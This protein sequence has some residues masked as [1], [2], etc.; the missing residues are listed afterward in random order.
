MLKV[1][2]VVPHLEY[3]SLAAQAM[4]VLLALPGEQVHRRVC[5][6]GRAGPWA[7]RLRH[8]GIEV[9]AA[10]RG[11]LFDLAP[12]A[13]LRRLVNEQTPD[14]VHAWGLS[15]LRALALS[16]FRGR[17]I[18]T[19]LA[20][21]S[22]FRSW[23][24]LLD[25]W[26]LRK[27]N[28]V[29]ALGDIDAERCSRLGVGAARLTVA[30]PAVSPGEGAPTPLP[31][32][33]RYLLC[34]GRLEPYKGFL[35]AI[36][37]HDILRYVHPEL[38]LVIVG[39]GPDRDRLQRFRDDVGSAATVDFVG[40]V[41]D[42]APLLRGAEVVWSPGRA[43]T[44]TQVVLEA[45]A[46]GKPVIASRWPRLAELIVDGE[47]GFLVPAQDQPALARRTEQLLHD[48]EFRRRIGAAAQARAGGFSVSALAE[49]C[50]RL[51]KG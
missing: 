29:L 47:T 21:P 38:R 14:A 40:A 9:H 33:T 23:S 8:A 4:Q 31:Q 7:D 42:V 28:H 49:C 15:A 48:A 20:A 32:S 16:R 2:F 24:R 50:L 27:A 3:S 26:L 18:A 34:V 51:Y 19:P 43:E 1:L 11:R 13:Q 10:G 36:W 25:G 45:M 22:V 41:E 37:A 46:A 12:L 5:V 30:H 39:A 6:L 35:D 17:L 44:G